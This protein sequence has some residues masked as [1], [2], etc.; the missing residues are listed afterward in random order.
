MTTT[1]KCPAS[2]RP[3]RKKLVIV[4]DT[5]GKTSLLMVFRTGKF[6][7]VIKNLIFYVILIVYFNLN[8]TVLF[9]YFI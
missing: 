1:S 8:I 2:Y 3:I 4:G 6:P 7:E 5:C 9:I